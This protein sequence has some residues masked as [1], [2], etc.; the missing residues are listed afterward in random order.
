MQR[1]IYLENGER[2]EP[3]TTVLHEF[4]NRYDLNEFDS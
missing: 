4:H 1:C 3:S 2:G